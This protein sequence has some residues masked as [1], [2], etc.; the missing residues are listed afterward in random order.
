MKINKNEIVNKQQQ[1]ASN[2]LA[3]CMEVK[4]KEKK[5]MISEIKKKRI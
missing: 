1:T 4:Y 5:K 2:S 3:H